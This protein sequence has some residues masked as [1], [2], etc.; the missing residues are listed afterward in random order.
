MKEEK[1]EGR[2]EKKE[3][4]RWRMM[5]RKGEGKRGRE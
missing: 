4:G 1:E 5:E 2:M 3:K